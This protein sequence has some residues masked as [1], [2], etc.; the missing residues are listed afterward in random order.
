MP[1]GFK[2]VIRTGVILF[3]SSWTAGVDYTVEDNDDKNDSS[4]EEINNNND[5]KEYENSDSDEN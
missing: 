5:Y 1:K 3:D 2:I 4:E